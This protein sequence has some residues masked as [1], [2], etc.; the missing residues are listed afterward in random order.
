MNDYEEA[1][2]IIMSQQRILTALT[3]ALN[4]CYDVF[5]SLKDN[6]VFDDFDAQVIEEVMKRADKLLEG[7]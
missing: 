2:D 6:Y 5:S 3:H 4:E 7:N 1:C